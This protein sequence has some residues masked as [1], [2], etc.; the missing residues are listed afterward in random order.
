MAHTRWCNNVTDGGGLGSHS[1]TPLQRLDT[2]LRHV[3]SQPCQRN[4][5]PIKMLGMG[6]FLGRPVVRAPHF[7]CRD[8]SLKP[9]RGTKI[10]QAA[11]CGQKKEKKKQNSG[12]EGSGVLLCLAIAHTC[13][14]TSL[15]GELSTFCTIPLERGNWI[16]M[17]GLPRTLP[18]V[19]FPLADFNL[20]L[21]PVIYYNHEY[22][23]FQ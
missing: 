13:Y 16:L 11:Q 15:L 2:K 21:C 17:P 9:G 7:R 18:H 5:L 4:Q 19:P 10:P 20:Y 14:H 1:I 3:G 8:T 22:K 12:C 6:E 23:S